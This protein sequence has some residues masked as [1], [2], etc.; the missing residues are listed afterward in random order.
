MNENMNKIIKLALEKYR[1]IY[2]FCNAIEINP[3]Y[4]R[5]NYNHSR[6]DRI[7]AIAKGLNMDFDEICDMCN[8]NL[9][10]LQR[11]IF[12]RG[13]TINEFCAYSG[14]SPNL[15]RSICLKKNKHFN[16]TYSVLSDA[17]GLPID[18]VIRICNA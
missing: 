6:G 7:Y 2:D 5:S 17:L 18:E 8:P 11:E 4:F 1:T 13:Y 16:S 3:G 10:P 15:I 14:L 9:H 12:K